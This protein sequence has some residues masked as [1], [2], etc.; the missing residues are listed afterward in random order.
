MVNV[1]YL[2]EA[3]IDVNRLIGLCEALILSG[4]VFIHVDKKTKDKTFWDRLTAYN[5]TH[6]QVKVL[7]HRKYVAWAGFSQVEAF[8]LLLGGHYHMIKLMTGLSCCPDWI[9]LFGALDKYLNI[10]TCTDS[11]NMSV[12][13]IS[14]S[15]KTTANYTKSRTII[16]SGTYRCRISL[17]Y[18]VRL[19]VEQCS[20]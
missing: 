13:M 2:I 10:L 3:H 6:P 17:Y 20:F 16:S 9:I 4:D 19:L 15:V 8:K 5:E 7:I 14:Q 12:V 1:A 11:R 18:D